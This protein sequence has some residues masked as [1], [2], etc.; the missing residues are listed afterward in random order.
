MRHTKTVDA[1]ECPD[2]YQQFSRAID[3]L[4]MMPGIRP[5]VAEDFVAI[6]EQLPCQSQIGQQFVSMLF[7]DSTTAID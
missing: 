7:N 2:S 3:E 5:T 1:D 4:K 6:R